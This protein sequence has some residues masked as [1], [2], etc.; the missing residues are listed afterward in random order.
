MGVTARADVIADAALVAPTQPGVYF[1]LGVDRVV[2]YVGKATNLRARLGQHA[3]G[4]DV[5]VVDV[6]WEVTADAHAAAA[7]E[8]DLIVALQPRCNRSIVMEGRWAYI[9]CAPDAAG[10]AMRF[11]VGI[12]SEPAPARVYGCFPHLGVDVSSQ[13]GIACSDGYVAFLRTLWA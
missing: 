7:R 11:T 5:P 12:T 10:A 8:A 2:L 13:A 1:F 3:R 6:A 9:S 4:T